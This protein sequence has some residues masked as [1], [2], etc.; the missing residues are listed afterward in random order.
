MDIYSY[1]ES[2][3]LT[4]DRKTYGGYQSDFV[5]KVLNSRSILGVVLDV[6]MCSLG[7]LSRELIFQVLDVC[8]LNDVLIDWNSTYEN[9]FDVLVKLLIQEALDESKK[10]FGDLHVP[11]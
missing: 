5:N 10:N 4:L 6:H 1:P 8:L 7:S 9:K 11:R 3:M 2:K